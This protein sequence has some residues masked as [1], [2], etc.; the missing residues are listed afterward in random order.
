MMQTLLVSNTI[1]DEQKAQS[2]T[3][4]QAEKSTG[5]GQKIRTRPYA[6]DANET[7]SPPNKQLSTYR[8][9]D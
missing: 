1:L 3:I 9:K 5:R 2:Q 8:A 6:F 7:N 4:T